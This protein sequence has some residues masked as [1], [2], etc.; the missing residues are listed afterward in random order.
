MNTDLT[1]DTGETMDTRHDG[2]TLHLAP[3]GEIPLRW[4]DRNIEGWPD[5]NSGLLFGGY[6]GLLGQKSKQL[7]GSDDTEQIEKFWQRK[8]ER[9]FWQ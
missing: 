1:D 6:E 3:D 7:I 9:P 8:A 4:K 5:P 2:R